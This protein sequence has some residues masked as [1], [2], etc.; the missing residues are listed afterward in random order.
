LWDRSKDCKHILSLN[1]LTSLTQNTTRKQV[2][3]HADKNKGI[4]TEVIEITVEYEESQQDPTEVVV[5]D[6]LFRWKKAEV[7]RQGCLFQQLID[8]SPNHRQEKD[9]PS[10]IFWK[11]E[12]QPGSKQKIHYTV[13]YSNI[14]NFGS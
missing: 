5:E 10:T 4:I 14:T 11:L 2:S 8:S 13:V 6:K 12:V 1:Q 9:D 7:I 3:F